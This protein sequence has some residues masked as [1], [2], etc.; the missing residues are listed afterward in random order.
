MDMD[1][2]SER[3][4]EEGTVALGGE[5]V[6]SRAESQSESADGKSMTLKGASRKEEPSKPYLSRDESTSERGYS[7]HAAENADEASK[8]SASSAESPIAIGTNFTTTDNSF[9]ASQE[10]EDWQPPASPR[11]NPIASF[12]DAHVPEPSVLTGVA[13]GMHHAYVVPALEPVAEETP[14]ATAVE[15]FVGEAYHAEGPEMG[16]KGPDRGADAQPALP[17]ERAYDRQAFLPPLG[18]EQRH[19]LSTV[20]DGLGM[21]GMDQGK[22]VDR[23][24][25]R[26][27]KPGHRNLHAFEETNTIKARHQ[28]SPPPSRL[29]RH[30]PPSSPPLTH[31]PLDRTTFPARPPTPSRIRREPPRNRAQHTEFPALGGEDAQGT[32]HE[33]G[34]GGMAFTQQGRVWIGRP[35]ASLDGVAMRVTWDRQAVER[36]RMR[37]VETRQGDG[38]RTD[39]VTHQTASAPVTFAPPLLPLIPRFLFPRLTLDFQWSDSLLPADVR[40]QTIAHPPASAHSISLSETL[41]QWLTDAAAPPRK[42]RIEHLNTRGKE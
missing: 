40:L 24:A 20:G 5:V 9:Q 11:L 31:A 41:R 6:R 23:G 38:T 2:G 33:A 42:R 7:Q 28:A 8:V 29:A 19:S 36:E 22:A 10:P 26:T 14:K 16:R 35:P 4:A 3:E 37:E 21:S 25:A 39:M 30:T 27:D 18:A 17:E 32:Y 13:A 12:P 1:A 15:R 34:V